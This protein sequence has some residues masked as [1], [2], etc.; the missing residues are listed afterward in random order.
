[1]VTR[2]GTR[3]PLDE[4]LRHGVREQIAD[5]VPR[6]TIAA[7]TGLTLKQVDAIRAYIKIRKELTDRQ[8]LRHAHSL[9]KARARK[10]RLKCLEFS[11]CEELW[12]GQKGRC[13][14][15]GARFS[16]R[17][18]NTRA[19][20]LSRPWRPSLDRINS[21]RGYERRNVRLVAQIVNFG[22][23]EWPLA[24]FRDMCRRVAKNP[25]PGR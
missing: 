3:H 21:K 1:M 9:A 7:E 19:K 14:I 6:E 8:M 16:D 18:V 13:A 10:K 22:L 12:E 4:A 17:Q 20:V 24:V 25:R 23:G 5:G 15:S 11:E 2:R